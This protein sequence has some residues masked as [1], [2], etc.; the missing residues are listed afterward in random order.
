MKNI[1]CLIAIFI[2]TQCVSQSIWKTVGVISNGIPT[3]TINTAQAIT[4]YNANLLQAS[5]INGNFT[6]LELLQLG[7]GTYLLIF[8][9]ET[10]S[11][12]FYVKSD[13]AGNLMASAGLSCTTS[14]CS[15]ETYGCIPQYNGGD[16]GSCTPCANG[17]VC[18]KTVSGAALF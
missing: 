9:G 12:S 11:S 1:L 10:Y 6:S 4:D 16:I 13:A 17:G 14:A 7:N 2:A 3:L 18:T 5:G 15:Q 8:K